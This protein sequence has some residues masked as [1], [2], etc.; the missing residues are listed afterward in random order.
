MKNIKLIAVFIAGLSVTAFTAYAATID[1]NIISFTQYIQE[2]FVTS[3]GTPN[4]NTIM[5]VDES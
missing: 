5:R 2:L 3:D 4:G 1:A